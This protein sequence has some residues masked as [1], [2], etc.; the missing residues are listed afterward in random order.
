MLRLFTVL[1]QMRPVS[2]ALAPHLTW[3][4]A[5][6]IKFGIDLLADA[7]AVTVGSNQSSRVW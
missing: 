6:D 7:I 2:P 4:Y 1:C 3:A 5:K